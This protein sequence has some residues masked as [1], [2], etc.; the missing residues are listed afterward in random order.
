MSRRQLIRQ[1][2]QERFGEGQ[3]ISTTSPTIS[4]PMTT[5]NLA[6]EVP[7]LA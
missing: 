2:V 5:G 4:W 6:G 3:P 7:T 1:Q